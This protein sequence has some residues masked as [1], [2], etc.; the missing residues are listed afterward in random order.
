[1]ATDLSYITK[2]GSVGT[3]NANL[4]NPS[5]F[6]F[7]NE[8]LYIA[9]T[10]NGRVLKW[11]LRGGG[12]ITQNSD[13]F[14]SPK[15]VE[16]YRDRLF[17]VDSGDSKLHVLNKDLVQTKELGG[18]S[19]PVSIVLGQGN[20]FFVSNS[21]GNN[22]LKYDAD[23]LTL[24]ATLA[25][26]SVTGQIAYDPHEDAV[27]VVAGSGTKVEKYW[28]KDFSTN[29][30]SIEDADSVGSALQAV[31]GVTVKDHYV[32]LCE[33]NR[34]QVFDTTT[35]TTRTNAGTDGSGN[36]Q[37]SLGSY[38]KAKGDVLVFSDVGNDRISVWYGYKPSRGFSS[39]DAYTIGGFYSQNPFRPIGSKREGALATI[40]GTGQSDLAVNI[41][42]DPISDNFAGVE[43]T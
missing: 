34:I 33:A 39:G 23:A 22:V 26:G 41:E 42:E 29:L 40:G 6:A 30:D 31:G 28:A 16:I 13:D 27:Y 8:F 14:T 9:D 24:S 2:Y 20:R 12:Y 7:D 38:I 4:S 3:G 32:Y 18:F 25:V 11:R 1:M 5:G 19:K 21:T 37:I 17:V 35:V 36:L 15:D 43:E 10:A